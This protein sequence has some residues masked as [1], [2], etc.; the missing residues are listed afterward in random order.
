MST[1]Q[2][3]PQLDLKFERIVEVPRE[4][5]FKGWTDEQLLLEW[6]CPKPWNVVACEIDLRPGGKFFTVMQSPDGQK[7]PNNGCFLE[8][9]KNEKLVWTNAFL[10]GYRPAPAAEMAG[11]E[12]F[13]F[14]AII[15]FEAHEKGT[16]YSAI[17]KHRNEEDRKKHEAMGFQEGWGKAL[18]QLVEL[19]G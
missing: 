17:V 12:F 14:V 8:V 5:L 6:F 11:Q 16:K 15:L 9:I 3:N 13:S 7:F 4:F 19:A 1:D 18:D 10:E 2:F